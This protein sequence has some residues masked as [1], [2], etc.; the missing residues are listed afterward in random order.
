MLEGIADYH[1]RFVALAVCES[2]GEV[3]NR[4]SLSE[5]LGALVRTKSCSKDGILAVVR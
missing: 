1:L 4:D 3:V 2:A 5:V